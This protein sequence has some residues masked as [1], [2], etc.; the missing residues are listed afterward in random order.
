[1]NSDLNYLNLKEQFPL[2][3]DYQI[4]NLISSSAEDLLLE[5][6]YCLWLIEHKNNTTYS[7]QVK[8][9]IEKIILYKTNKYYE[10]E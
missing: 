8:R 5:M 7:Q 4:G 3:P 9:L 10:H 1:M 6:G 2:I